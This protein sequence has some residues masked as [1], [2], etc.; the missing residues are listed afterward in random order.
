MVIRPPAARILSDSR[1]EIKLLIR[2]IF[3]KLVMS[4]FLSGQ[5]INEMQLVSGVLSFRL[6]RGDSQAKG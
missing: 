4:V 5:R 6:F 1:R 3:L 2:M